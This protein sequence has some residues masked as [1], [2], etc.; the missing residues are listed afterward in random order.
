MSRDRLWLALAI[1]LP[2]LAATIA[3]MS[4][5]DLAYQVRAGELMLASGVALVRV[6]ARPRT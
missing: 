6:S 1:L 5:V 2:V 4:T 3:P